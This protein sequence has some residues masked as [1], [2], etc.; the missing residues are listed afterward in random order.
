MQTLASVTCTLITV[1]IV[2]AWMHVE[3]EVGDGV[4]SIESESEKSHIIAA[5]CLLLVCFG[6]L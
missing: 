2:M 3:M 5:L 4:R 6:L 1:T